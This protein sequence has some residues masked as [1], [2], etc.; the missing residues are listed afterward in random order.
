MLDV[1]ES[2]R[3]PSRSRAIA[4][5]PPSGVSTQNAVAKRVAQVGGPLGEAGHRLLAV[6]REQRP[7]PD[8]RLVGVGLHLDQRDR[9]LG[10]PA[11]GELDRVVAVLPALVGE[12][13]AGV[14][15]VAR[16]S[17]DACDC[18]S[19]HSRQPR[20]AGSSA[21][22]WRG[23]RPSRP[24][25][26]ACR[27]TAGSRRRCRSRRGGSAPQVEDTGP[28]LVE[29]LPRLLLGRRVVRA[30]LSPGERPQRRERQRGVGGHQHPR[31][32][33]GVAAEQG[34]EPRA[35][36]RDE[37]VAPVVQQQS[38]E[39]G[40]PCRTARSTRRS[41]ALT[42][43]AQPAG[44]PAAKS[45]SFAVDGP[46][47]HGPPLTPG[48]LN[49]HVSRPVVGIRFGRR[50]GRHLDVAVLGAP[51]RDLR[52]QRRRSRGHRCSPA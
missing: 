28:H 27:R 40:S 35:A 22:T 7:A 16:A 44:R 17:P 21:R 12:A 9:R 37:P 34:Q 43:A 46:D 38:R 6:R 20:A 23:R 29:D 36:G 41:E 32:P 14:V 51:A 31:G 4:A 39:V 11:V 10:Q 50:I 15:D 5:W 49:R 25:P 19:T 24:R 30:A 13:D 18:A 52:G 26:R 45:D 47:G 2:A 3:R 33:E 42:S 1:S 48:Q 8:G